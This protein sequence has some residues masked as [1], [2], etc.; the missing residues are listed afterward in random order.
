LSIG[1]R[2][3]GK[4]NVQRREVELVFNI[5][6]RK[7]TLFIEEEKALEGTLGDV[8]KGTP[9]IIRHKNKGQRIWGHL[10]K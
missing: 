9:S 5:Q 2:G 8:R 6:A 1:M 3:F 4:S 10:R 7:N